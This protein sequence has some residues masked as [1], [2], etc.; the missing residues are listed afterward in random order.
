MSSELDK[1]VL[2]GSQIASFP[3]NYHRINKAMEDHRSSMDTI[4]RIIS[5]DPGLTARL[6]KIAN[7][8]FYNTPFPVDTVTRALTMIGTKQLK[9]LVAATLITDMF[10]G[11]AGAK[12]DMEAF[13]KHSIGCG[14][15]A[16]VIATAKREINVERYYLTGLLH[17]VGR[18]VIFSKLSNQVDKLI[19]ISN[20]E[21]K[22]MVQTE[23]EILGFDHA[24]LGS[25]LLEKWQ[26]PADI[27]IPI[28]YHHTPALAKDYLLETSTIHVANIIATSARFGSSG[29]VRV[30]PLDPAAWDRIGLPVSSIP[31]LLEH[32]NSQFQDALSIFTD[33]GN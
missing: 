5:D 20:E 29:D 23:Q 21:K 1:L 15:M 8:S 12:V 32:A 6:L 27:Y 18:I 26:L 30:P 9:D 4:G 22:S 33:T 11:M 14:V 3:V 13:W 28:K 10:S 31:N 19:S 7:S 16:R 17:D 24:E 2:S 25:R